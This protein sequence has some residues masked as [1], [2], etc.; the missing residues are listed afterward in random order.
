MSPTFQTHAVVSVVA[1]VSLGSV[2]CAQKYIP[3][4]EGLRSRLML[5]SNLPA[6]RGALVYSADACSDPRLIEASNEHQW[7]E[8]D[9]TR[10]LS[11]KRHVNTLG[12]AHGRYCEKLITFVPAEGQSYVADFRVESSGCSMEIYRVDSDGIRSRET[13]A[14]L[15]SNPECSSN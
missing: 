10:P 1:I 9:A 11:L 3:H 4:T 6:A 7:I 13:S 15:I 12:L 2:G 14:R 5:V 8:V